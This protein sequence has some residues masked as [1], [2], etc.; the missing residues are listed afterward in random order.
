MTRR[1]MTW[2]VLAAVWGCASEEK[3]GAD[4]STT[5]RVGDWVD[6]NGD[7][8]LDGVAVDGDGDGIPDGVD[9]DGDGIADALL[10]GYPPPR[11]GN[12]TPGDG[13][14][15]SRPGD[16]D[17]D[18]DGDSRPGDGDGDDEPLVIE[19][20]VA[21]VP[22]G[23]AVCE[24]RHSNVC[25]D[26]WTR[27]GFGNVPMCI[28]EDACILSDPLRISDDGLYVEVEGLLTGFDPKRAVVSRCDGAEDCGAGQICCYV[29]Q[30]APIAESFNP[31]VW[32]GPGAGRQCMSAEDCTAVGAANG[33]PTGV[34][35]CNDD[36][37]CEKFAGTRCQPEQ[38]N[39][40]TTG[41][42]VIA[43]AGHMVCR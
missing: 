21:R 2:L 9:L 12:Q 19:I 25:C 16:G 5:V 24:I 13:D 8:Y 10:P 29:R 26:Y 38:D 3:P 32:V 35:S 43:R 34:A 4:A 27:A 42:N 36:R 33:V 14:G 40:A 23:A 17:G 18:G 15:G 31:P 6:I 30:G 20:P 22:C 41:K 7:G 1:A 28:T 11:S 39:S 37:D